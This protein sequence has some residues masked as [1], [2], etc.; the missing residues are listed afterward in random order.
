[1]RPNWHTAW[2]GNDIAVYRDGEIV[3]RVHGPD[4]QRVIFVY[5][6]AGQS[7][8]DLAYALVELPDEHVLFPVD[9]GF[10]GRV[11]F[12]RQ[13]F[14]AQHACVYWVSERKA[15]LPARHRPVGWWFRRRA[16]P[17]YRRLPR[18]ELAGVIEQ[19]PLQGPQTWQER[20]WQRIEDS[21]PL[22]DLPIRGRV[23]EDADKR[24][25]R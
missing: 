22:A 23:A 9:T 17:P 15:R 2:L 13:S 6:D 14:W 3:D 19:W 12:E 18:A 21:R 24:P 10:A 8:A 20:K 7:P 11:H 5:R 25:G 16:T 1:M 4:I